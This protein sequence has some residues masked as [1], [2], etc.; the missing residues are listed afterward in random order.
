MDEVI[1]LCRLHYS[2]VNALLISGNVNIDDRERY[3]WAVGVRLK[4]EFHNNF[5]RLERNVL[6]DKVYSR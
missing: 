6:I 1:E 5:E 3:W 4:S 2:R